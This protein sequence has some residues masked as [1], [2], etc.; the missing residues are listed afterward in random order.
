MLVV[1]CHLKSYIVTCVKVRR[2]CGVHPPFNAVYQLSQKISQLRGNVSLSIA[3]TSFLWTVLLMCKVCER[4][5]AISYNLKRK[6]GWKCSN[7][8]F[9]RAIR[10]YQSMEL[11]V[12]EEY[13][14][15][16]KPTMFNL[17][18]LHSYLKMSSMTGCSPLYHLCRT[19]YYQFQ[20][21]W[22]PSSHL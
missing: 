20:K 4:V 15:V 8:V 12:L 2:V 16:R 6:I 11:P 5:Y 21:L 7:Q 17:T 13:G 10:F 18:L 19:Q 3:I 14:F 1:T 9:F 22:F